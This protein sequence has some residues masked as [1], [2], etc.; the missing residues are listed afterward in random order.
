MTTAAAAHFSKEANG[1]T[2]I[3]VLVALAILGLSSV[4]LFGVFRQALSQEHKDAMSMRARILAQ[5]LLND[6]LGSSNVS[7]G[8]RSGQANDSLHWTIALTPYRETDQAASLFT[9]DKATIA[10][11]WETSD[12]PRRYSLATLIVAP[13]GG[14]R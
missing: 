11:S 9:V 4:V 1:F 13:N 10:V 3:E 2:L 12:G 5:S 7:I 6:T 8:M 14:A